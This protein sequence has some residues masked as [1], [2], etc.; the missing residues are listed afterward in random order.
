MC[1][2]IPINGLNV[3][4]DARI[5]NNCRHAGSLA[6]LGSGRLDNFTAFLGNR[7]RSHDLFTIRNSNIAVLSGARLNGSLG[8]RLLGRSMY[9]GNNHGFLFFSRLFP[10]L[11]V[12][13]QDGLVKIDL[14]TVE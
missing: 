14:D 9:C 7:L 5:A 4:G 1:S 11:L 6:L 8:A 13:D 3:F 2:N 10:Y 12:S